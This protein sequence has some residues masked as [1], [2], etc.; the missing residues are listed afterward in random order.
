M[1]ERNFT[2]SHSASSLK[3]KNSNKLGLS[4][5]SKGLG[6]SA[7]PVNKK[8]APTFASDHSLKAN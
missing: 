8:F 1:T 6:Q 4:I 3:N 5:F 7:T 2:K